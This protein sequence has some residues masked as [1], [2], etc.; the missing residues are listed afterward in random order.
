MV[1]LVS[2][3][4]RGHVQIFTFS[5][6]LKDQNN[7]NFIDEL[8][9]LIENLLADKNSFD[10]LTIEKNEHMHSFEQIEKS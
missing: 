7:K 3:N 4:A 6:T 8:N 10:N 9:N 1:K 5:E 2:Q